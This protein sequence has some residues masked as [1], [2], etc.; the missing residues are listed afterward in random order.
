MKYPNTIRLMC[1][2]CSPESEANEGLLLCSNMEPDIN[3]FQTHSAREERKKL[4]TLELTRKKMG[5][6]LWIYA[7]EEDFII[8]FSSF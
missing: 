5:Q 4:Q 7:A 1:R 3:I 6:R 2:K 8:L